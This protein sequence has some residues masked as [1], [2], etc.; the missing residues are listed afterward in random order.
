MQGCLVRLGIALM[1]V[2]ALPAS[3]AAYPLEGSTTE[4]SVMH[5]GTLQL[6]VRSERPT[7]NV[8]IWRQS[9]T[10]EFVQQIGETIGQLPPIPDRAWE[11]C[12]WPVTNSIRVDPSWKP[13]AY[14]A[15][16]DATNVFIWIP[17]V[18]RARAPGRYGSILVQLSINTWQAYNRY[19]GKNLYGA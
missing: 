16:L 5:G 18:V 9:R 3:A 6:H 8:S 14:V 15:R 2:L 17:F 12:D 1:L 7:Y 10:L 4:S 13:G 11:G 19:G